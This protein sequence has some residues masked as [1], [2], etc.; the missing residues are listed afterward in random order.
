MV[1]RLR[2]DD[3]NPSPK[4]TPQFFTFHYSLYLANSQIKNGIVIKESAVLC[5]VPS[6]V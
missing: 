2:R 4:G 1:S 6:A 5:R 3:L